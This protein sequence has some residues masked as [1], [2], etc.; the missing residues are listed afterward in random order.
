[1]A[2]GHPALLLKLKALIR[3]GG[4]MALGDA[5]AM[6]REKA[7]AYYRTMS[8]SDFQAMAAFLAA[9]RSKR[10]KPKL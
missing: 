7:E 1:M 6:E 4:D 9:K 10:P 2:D 5:R 3:D 8:A